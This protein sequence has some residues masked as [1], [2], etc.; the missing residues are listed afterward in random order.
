[1]VRRERGCLKSCRAFLG[2]N[3]LEAGKI[4]DIKVSGMIKTAVV[5]RKRAADMKTRIKTLF[6]SLTASSPSHRCHDHKSWVLT[7]EVIVNRASFANSP[8]SATVSRLLSASN[9]AL[10][11]KRRAMSKPPRPMTTGRPGTA[12]PTMS[13]SPVL[14][15]HMQR[16]YFPRQDVARKGGLRP[17]PCADCWAFV[18]NQTR[19]ACVHRFP[20]PEAWLLGDLAAVD[21]STM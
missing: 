5:A 4:G 13:C 17:P 16:F 20:A 1:M 10:A 12:T 7:F 21:A 11:S 9:I 2:A 14:G 18:E 3:G 6:F 19:C 15:L 8:T